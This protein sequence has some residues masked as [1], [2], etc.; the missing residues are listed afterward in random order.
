MQTRIRRW[1]NSLGVRI[2]QAVAERSR[3]TE[4]TP[5]EIFVRQ[6]DVVI[7]P[8]RLHLED[9][10]TQVTPENCHTATDWGTPQGQEWE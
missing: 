5:V 4:G 10:L 6:S 3:L 2:P 1:G 8:K 7:R 9:L